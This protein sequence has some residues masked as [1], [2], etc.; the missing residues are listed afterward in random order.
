MAIYIKID[1]VK[2][3]DDFVTY[4]FDSDI[5]ES[6]DIGI[7]EINKKNGNC[8]IIQELSGD[9][10]NYLLN[11]AYRA[12]LRHWKKGEFPDKTCWAS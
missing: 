8:K 5:I 6:D 11:L 3:N 1:K 10:N 2:E 7:L 12:I 9:T 4:Q